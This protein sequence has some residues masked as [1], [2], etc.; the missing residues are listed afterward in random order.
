MDYIKHLIECKCILPQ[1]K[2]RKP[3]VFHSFVVFSVIEDNGDVRLSFAQCPNCGVIHKVTEVGVSAILRKEEM[4]SLMTVDEIKSSLPEN[5]LKIL[6]TYELPL[7]TWQEIS[8]IF[9]NEL[10]GK[11]PVILSKEEV[12]G[13]TTGKYLAILG[14]ELFQ[15][16]SFTREEYV[17]GN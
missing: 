9:D 7:P 5:L 13:I 15:I 2:N 3:P 6:S 10:W 8:F 11:S 12:E 17:N 4:S 1:F 16:K 14:K